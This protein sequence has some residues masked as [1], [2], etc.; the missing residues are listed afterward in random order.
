[1]A[2]STQRRRESHTASSWI[3]DGVIGKENYKDKKFFAYDHY[4]DYQ[5]AYRAAKLD[6]FKHSNFVRNLPLTGN[7]RLVRKKLLI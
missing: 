5:E 3:H 2:Q 6:G 1:M 7:P 4:F